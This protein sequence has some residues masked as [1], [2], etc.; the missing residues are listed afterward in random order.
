[1]T[2]SLSLGVLMPTRNCAALLRQGMAALGSW[3]DLAE[4]VVVVDSESRD[5]TMEF[6]QSKLRHRNLRF[7]S[8]PPGLYQSWNFGIRH[9]NTEFAYVSTAGDAITRE[10]LH[11]LISAAQSLQCDVVISKPEIQDL[12][13]QPADLVWPI[14][15]IISSL[16]ISAPRK[17]SRVEALVFSWVH[18]TD[19][20]TGSCASD[21]FRS[22]CLKQFPF[23]TE[24][25]GA[26]DGAWGVMHAAEV[27]WAVVPERFSRFVRHPATA[28]GMTRPARR[29]TKRMDIVMREAVSLW[30]QTGRVSEEELARAGWP[31]IRDAFTAWLDAKLE[32]DACRR[33]AWPWSLNPLAWRIRS[34]RQKAQSRLHALKTSVLNGESGGAA[35]SPG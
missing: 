12:E 32:F 24:F 17:L 4:E 26:G 8:H 1:M 3:L 6:L 21:L 20:M 15:D 5:G 25:G 13:G 16:R 19:A 14:D 9:L 11:R 35:P 31:E 23:P 10:G 28:G 22:E 18:G 30:L 29:E 2:P 7:L 34:R 27:A 33:A